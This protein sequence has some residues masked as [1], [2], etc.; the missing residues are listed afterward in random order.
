M[1]K[2]LKSLNNTVKKH[3]YI[4]LLITVM[5][6]ILFYILTEKVKEN[7]QSSV[8][9]GFDTLG[10]INNT[11][12][13]IKNVANNIPNQINNIGNSIKNSENMITSSVNS[14][15]G[16]INNSFNSVK[17]DV[18]QGFNTVK[19]TATQLNKEIEDKLVKFGKEI[20]QK[21]NDLVINK[22]KSFFDQLGNILNQAIVVPFKTLFIGLGDVFI[23]IFE[24][25]KM[26]GDKIVSLPNCIFIYGIKSFTDTVQ[27]IYR[28]IIPSFI[29]NVIT[30]IYN[31][32]F[33]WLVDY[34]LKMIG[35][36]GAVER[37]YGFN[38]NDKVD[39]MNN[40]FKNISRTFNSSFG[41]IKN[42]PIRL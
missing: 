5:I 32:L 34:L 23:Q 21:T 13:N 1:L 18:N 41:N 31:F 20:E 12:N 10:D 29:R 37:C 8:K 16:T 11:I 19:N 26:I 17:T 30:S 27:S 28:Y 38:V 40:I 7:F 15:T 9:E 14:A 22:I 2:I 4:S 36:T 33:K 6:V 39:N 25:I 35:Y 3:L 42:N 24:I